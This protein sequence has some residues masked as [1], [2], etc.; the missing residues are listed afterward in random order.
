MEEQI[1]SNLIGLQVQ[2][3]SV[4]VQSRL[5]ALSQTLDARAA[6]APDATAQATALLAHTVQREAFVMAYADA[7]LAL[8]VTFL[9]ATLAV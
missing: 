6:G 7:F 4:T 2:A 3:G 9:L 1:H 5:D 8:G